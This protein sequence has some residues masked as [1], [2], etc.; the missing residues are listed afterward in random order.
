MSDK[1]PRL[2]KI[3]RIIHEVE[4]VVR[5]PSF[6][7]ARGTLTNVE[8]IL[9]CNGII[10]EILVPREVGKETEAQTRQES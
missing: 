9:I 8:D 4:V 1:L 7:N 5:E 2:A 3:R 6:M 10:L